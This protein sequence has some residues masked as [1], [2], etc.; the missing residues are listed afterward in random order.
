MNRGHLAPRHWF[1]ALFMFVQGS[2]FM[3]NLSSAAGRD[4]WISILL[5]CALGVGLLWAYLLLLQRYPRTGLY[6]LFFLG[7]GRIV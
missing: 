2:A 4:A 3:L 6:D 5:A 7:F 1:A